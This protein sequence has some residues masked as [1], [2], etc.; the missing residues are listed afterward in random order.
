MSALFE[1]ET[2]SVHYLRCGKLLHLF[3]I[4]TGVRSLS[5]VTEDC[6]ADPLF[7]RRCVSSVL[8]NPRKKHYPYFYSLLLRLD[9]YFPYRPRPWTV[10]F[11]IEKC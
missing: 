1:C 8:L 11:E 4:D 6:L 2:S 3:L 10:D 7:K 5:L 9:I